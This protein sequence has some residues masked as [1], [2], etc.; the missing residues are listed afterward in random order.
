MIAEKANVDNDKNIR[1]KFVSGNRV[2]YFKIRLTS[3]AMN[4]MFI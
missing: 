2:P 4:S 3:S 1:P